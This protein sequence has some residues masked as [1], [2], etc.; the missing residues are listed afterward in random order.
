MRRSSGSGG[1]GGAVGR[2]NCNEFKTKAPLNYGSRVGCPSVG[3][4]HSS[5]GPA[6]AAFRLYL[7][8]FALWNIFAAPLPIGRGRF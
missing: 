3:F 4:D 1:V 6:D 2:R 7:F 8:G 5:S